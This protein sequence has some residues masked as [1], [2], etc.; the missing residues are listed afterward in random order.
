[1]EYKQLLRTK[2]V[3]KFLH[4]AV[5]KI[6]SISDGSSSSGAEM[7][8]INPKMVVTATVIKVP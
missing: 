4:A 8:V 1:M 7:N 3:L 6:I 5:S 2:N